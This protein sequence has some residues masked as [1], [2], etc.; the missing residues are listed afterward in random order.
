MNTLTP[1][2]FDRLAKAMMERHGVSHTRARE[3]LGKLK[4]HLMCGE[5]IRTS[6]ALQAA[7]LTAVNTGKRAFRGGV[8]IELPPDVTLRVP[9]PTPAT[10]NGVAS[11]LGATAAD[12]MRQEGARSLVFGTVRMPADSLRVFCDGWRGGVLPPNVDATFEPGVDFALGGVFAGAFA[13]ARAFLSAAEISRRDIAEAT[14][15]SLWR[16]DLDWL[17]QEACGPV[18]ENL[19]AKLWLLGLGHL[20]QAYVWS[21]GLLPF[22]KAGSSTVY[23]QDFE[24][25]EEANWSAGLLCEMDQVGKLKTRLCSHWLEERRFR[26]RII[27]RPFNVNT[28]RAWDEPRI[29]LCGFD[30]PEPRRLLEDAG[31]ELIVEAGLGGTLDRFDRIV[32]HTFPEASAS[33]REIWIAG[34]EKQ[35]ELDLSLFGD[36]KSEC[37]IVLQDIAGKA[38]SSS[39]TGACASALAIGEILRAIHGGRRCEFIAVHLRDFERPINP[40]RIEN[41]QLRVAR[42]GLVRA[43]QN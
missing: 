26:T 27:E 17:S 18:L 9:W 38:I 7:L 13:V 39:F 37:G 12:S 30:K 25:V 11:N 14:G 15:L 16:P 23:L 41:Y 8:T 36:D 40:Y 34:P 19:P 29:A 2:N 42:N 35:S 4:L 20:G 6:A 21:L 22:P 32:L 31:F 33:P 24:D 5:E 43:G 1:Q 28:R 10:L 3:M